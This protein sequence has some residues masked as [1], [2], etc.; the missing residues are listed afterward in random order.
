MTEPIMVSSPIVTE[1]PQDRHEAAAPFPLLSRYREVRGASVALC[2]PL[3]IE[4][5]GLQGMADTS[6]PKWHL[7][8]TSWF[9]ET[10]LLKPFANGYRAFHPQFEYLFNSYYEAVGA[11]FP[12]PQRGLLSRPTVADVAAY[13]SYVDTAMEALLLE[14]IEDR[15]TVLSRTALGINHEEQ[16]QELL[17]T[18]IK[19]SLSINPLR[20]AY[21]S[22]P[23]PPQGTPTAFGWC[24]FEQSVFDVGFAGEGFAFDNE[25]PRHSVYLQPYALASR[26]VTNGEFLEF[27]EAGG[28]SKSE[29]W[30]SDAWRC[31]REKGWQAPL[32][33]ER[34]TGQWWQYTLGGM[35]RLSEHQPV[36]HV[37]FYEADAYARF[38]G[39]RL[40]T[41]TEWEAAATTV[42]V[43]GNLR[44]G[45]WLHPTPCETTASPAQMYGDVWEWTASA[46]QPYPRYRPAAGALGEYNG[47]FMTNQMVL[48]GGSCVTPHAHIR[49]TYRNF[50]Y[51]P[52]RWQFSGIRLA[53]DR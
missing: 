12:R 7:A 50:F 30:L 49:P 28:Y 47:K 33:W 4:D 8:H 31:V 41:E 19:Y 26:L 15:E 43:A 2:Q 36:C 9:F 23:E 18:D 45:G 32:Y 10:F 35:R 42:S 38:R 13:R 40:A 16:H 17:L 20:P 53:D 37:S 39:M 51:P 46:Y 1:T 29:Y 52:D 22:L 6:P 3:A 34:Q 27:M 11:Q 24:E 14:D 44:E 5:Y 25:G 21:H 48:R